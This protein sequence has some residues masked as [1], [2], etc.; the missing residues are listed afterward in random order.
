MNI[1]YAEASKIYD[2]QCFV[3]HDVDLIPEND[4]NI[5]SCPKQPRHMSAAID[6]F[7]YRLVYPCTLL[8]RPSGGKNRPGSVN[9]VMYDDVW[10]KPG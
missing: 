2:Y 1:G 10:L 5:Y 7:K 8:H 3:F 4:R 9:Y 6:K